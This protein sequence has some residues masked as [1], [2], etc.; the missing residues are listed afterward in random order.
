[1]ATSGLPKKYRE[2]LEQG[3]KLYAD[4]LPLLSLW[5]EVADNFYPERADF[6]ISRSLGREFAENLTTSYP[7][8]ARRD[9][10]N[11][12]SS[13]LRPTEKQWFHNR[14]QKEPVM[15]D[16][17]QWLEWSEGTMRRA[18]YDRASQFVR[19]TKEAD[20]DFAAFG[21][22]VISSEIVVGKQGPHLLYRC[23]HLRDV[24]W[25]ENAH[26]Q[27]D[28]VYCKLKLTARDMVRLFKGNV[29]RMVTL[30]NEKDPYKEYDVR[31]V[32]IS[33]EYFA[34]DAKGRRFPYISLYIDVD[35]QFILEETPSRNLI[36]TIPRWQTVS[37][38]QYAFSPATVAALP[39][40][41]LIQQ[42]AYT[43]LEAGQVAVRPPM[44]A[45][46][47]AVR[48]DAQLFSGG[49]TWVDAEYDGKLSEAMRPVYEAHDGMQIGNEMMQD[50]RHMIAE[51]FFL[52]KLN[53]PQRTNDMTAYEVSQRIQEYIRNALPLFEPMEMDYNGA[54]CE[55]TFDL[56]MANGAFGNPYEIPPALKGQDIQFRFESPLHD[57]LEAVKPQKFLEARQMLEQVVQLDPI[58][59]RI[60]NQRTALRDALRGNNTP[61]TWIRTEKEML[62]IDQAEQ[63]KAAVQNMLGVMSQGAQVA[64]QMG[65]AASAIK[66]AGA[67]VPPAQAA[68]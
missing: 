6:T 13:M 26:R 18:M 20:H 46:Q 16:S 66:Q 39:D 47:E 17:R 1:M 4:R 28:T 56:L 55:Q 34:D 62:Q 12:F 30:A 60:I 3:E 50:I 9:L 35:N 31:H 48:S 29:H 27:I 25:C 67:P 32:V 54:L 57:A 36:Y 44:M 43:L 61:A 63:E 7:I 51:A 22:A 38:S 37:G 49:F 10:G 65:T 33:S 42:M 58:S 45:V 52:N 41:R 53:L 14:V 59:A 5:Q 64:E 23:R 68:A 8:I 11:A 24:V 21:Q 2:L 15:E 19:A 40:A